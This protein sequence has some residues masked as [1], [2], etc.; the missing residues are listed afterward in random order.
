VESRYLQDPFIYAEHPRPDWARRRWTSLDGRWLLERGNRQSEIIVPFPIGS[1]ASQVTWQPNGTF[2]YRRRFSLPRKPG[3][4]YFLYIGACDYRAQVAINGHHLGTHTGGYTSFS[5]EITEHVRDAENELAIRVFDSRRMTQIRGKQTFRRGPFSVWY[6]GIAGLW[7]S[8]WIEETGELYIGACRTTPD[9]QKHHIQFTFQIAGSFPDRPAGELPE[10]VVL[11]LRIRS[12]TGEEHGFELEHAPRAGRVE[13]VVSFDEIGLRLWSPEHPALYSATYTLR[14]RKGK[15]LDAVES[16]FGVRDIARN[17]QGLTI[18]G[19]AVY[20]RMV[21]VQ[22][23][24]PGGVYT[25]LHYKVMDEDIRRA[26]DCGYN[27][28]RVHQKIEDPYFHYLCDRHGLLTSYEIP[29]FYRYRTAVERQ[30]RQELAEVQ[31]RDGQHPSCIFWVLF[32]ESWGM[33]RM[34][35]KRSRARAFLL[36]M[37][38]FLRSRDGTRP[39]ID[40]SGWEHVRTDIVDIHHYLRSAEL[41][42]AFYRKLGARDQRTLYRFSALS[43]MLF[44]LFHRIG[45]R[46]RTVL[47]TRDGHDGAPWLLSEYGGFGWYRVDSD[48]SQLALIREY[49]RDAVESGLFCGYCYTQLYDVGSETNGL[50]TFDRIAKVAPSAIREVNA[51]AKR[52]YSDA[53]GSREKPPARPATR[54]NLT[55]SP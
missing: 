7:Q 23:Y 51:L 9:F 42:R 50:F 46:T 17:P 38:D 27:G 41:G 54:G 18:N 53:S 10:T 19:E 5:Y 52:P 22:G 37:V 11:E 49:T 39:V 21:L 26:M 3:N 12:E 2:A 13:K 14:D 1:A 45:E 30:F 44:Y 32:N 29:S 55:S 47:L 34:F 6:N 48:Q 16:Y 43:V 20:L 28:I 35:P 15:I 31:E 40:N 36:E 25:P 4:R 8:V 24:F 33:H